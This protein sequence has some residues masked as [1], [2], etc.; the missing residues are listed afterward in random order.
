M[1]DRAMAHLNSKGEKITPIEADERRTLFMA[2]IFGIPPKELQQ[3]YDFRKYNQQY[4]EK[5]REST[6]AWVEIARRYAGSP[7]L[8]S[9][10][11][12]KRVYTMIQFVVSDLNENERS[13]VAK[14]VSRRLSDDEYKLSSELLKVLDTALK[15]ENVNGLEINTLLLPKEKVE[16]NAQ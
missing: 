5:I 10:A 7:V 12:Q 2:R 4:E 13:E 3:Y 14:R 16:V 1:D 15:Q 9:E 11:G 8:E 6:D